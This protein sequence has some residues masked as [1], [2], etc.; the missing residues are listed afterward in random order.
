M[1]KK[2][3]DTIKEIR[4]II[5]DERYENTNLRQNVR[6]I[7]SNLNIIFEIQNDIKEIKREIVNKDN[8]EKIIKGANFESR[9]I[10]FDKYKTTINNM[11]AYCQDLIN[12]KLIQYA[13]KNDVF[14]T[15]NEAAEL[16]EI[17]PEQALFG[18]MAK[19]IGSIRN[20]LDKIEKDIYSM[21]VNDAEGAEYS[22]D[23]WKEKIG[24]N[25][26]YLLILYAMISSRIDEQAYLRDT[27]MASDESK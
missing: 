27:R 23:I 26:T 1:N 7:N 3:K 12:D 19:H 24:D 13:N 2:I 5:V 22:L 15:F 20:M 25:I 4:N 6:D 16:Q 18:M 10:S 9:Y 8:E 11:I 14:K 21:T 17:L